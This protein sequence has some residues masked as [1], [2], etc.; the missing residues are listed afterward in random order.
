MPGKAITKNKQLNGS[1][2]PISL[3]QNFTRLELLN[4]M[5]LSEEIIYKFDREFR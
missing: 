4:E 5:S 3:L 2:R 1:G